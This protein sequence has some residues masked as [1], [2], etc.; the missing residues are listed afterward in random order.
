MFN[1]QINLLKIENANIIMKL[2]KKT[3][4]IVSLIFGIL[5]LVKPDILAILVA[6]YLIIN[7]I[8]ELLRS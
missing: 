5:I 8:V 2:D 4:A 3:S 6:L 1:K 7:G